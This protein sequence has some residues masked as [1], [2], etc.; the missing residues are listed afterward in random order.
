MLVAKSTSGICIGLMLI[1][2]TGTLM[3]SLPASR[4]RICPRRA[5]TFV[6]FNC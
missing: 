2:S 4:I 5:T 1:A 3:A 6:F